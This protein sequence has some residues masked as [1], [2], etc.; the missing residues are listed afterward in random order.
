MDYR[1][2]ATGILLIAGGVDA[3]VVECLEGGEGFFEEFSA[4]SGVG[5]LDELN[6]NGRFD[7]DCGGLDPLADR[8]AF[9]CLS[10][11]SA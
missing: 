7:G 5:A 9:C 11:A 8:F 6:D 2:I 3:V 10:L 4:F 1:D